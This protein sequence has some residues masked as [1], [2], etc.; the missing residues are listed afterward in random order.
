M[1]DFEKMCFIDKTFAPFSF[2]HA[3]VI[4]SR[5]CQ[6]QKQIKLYIQK[7]NTFIKKL[8]NLLHFEDPLICL[9][10]T[11]QNYVHCYKTV[12]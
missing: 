2:L 9:L 8:I 12:F 7:I 4:F 11:E 5:L 6:F 3:A 1:R 10:L